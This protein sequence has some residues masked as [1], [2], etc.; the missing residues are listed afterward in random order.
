MFIARMRGSGALRQEG[1]VYMER[2]W[3]TI[4]YILLNT[5][6]RSRGRSA[7]INDMALL[8]EGGPRSPID[9]KHCPPDG[10][11]CTIAHLL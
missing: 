11:R 6:Y 4:A 10:G 8:T 3:R 5:F 2:R 7:V 9:Y 1:H